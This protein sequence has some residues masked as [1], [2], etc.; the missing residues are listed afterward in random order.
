MCYPWSPDQEAEDESP[1]APNSRLTR[2]L[3]IVIEALGRVPS[4]NIEQKIRR[5]LSA[6]EAEL[7]AAHRF[8][9]YIQGFSDQK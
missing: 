2:T 4:S 8:Y 5:S 1:A 7:D 3:G 6:E 9:D